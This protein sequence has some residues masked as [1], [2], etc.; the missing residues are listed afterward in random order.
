V[1]VLGNIGSGK[2]TVSHS[3]SKVLGW[4]SYGID[5]AR[6]AHGDGSPAGEARAW[7]GFLERAE[8]DSSVFLECTGAGP[9]M[10][11]FRL[12]L[13]RSSHGWTVLWVDT[14]PE[15][16]LRRVGQRGLDIPYPDFGVPLEQVIPA[17]ARHLSLALE[18]SWGRPLCRVDGQGSVEQE[19]CAAAR[20]L[21]AWWESQALP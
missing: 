12:A 11:L 7:A 4:S 3:L 2:S 14:P 6:R 5:D 20:R 13:R 15:E 8:R 1:V 10:D 9:F 19:V 21:S 18:T 17:V 16:C